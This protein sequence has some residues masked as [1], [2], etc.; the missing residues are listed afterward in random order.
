MIS[1][2]VSPGLDPLVT[3]EMGNGQ[4]NFQPVEVVVDTGFT[5]ELAL[6]AEL[7]QSLGLDY[8]DD[9]RVVLADRV[10][11]WFGAYDGVM[12]WHGEPISVIVLETGGDSLLGMGLLLGSKLTVS[13]RPGGA[14]LIEDE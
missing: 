5:G 7:I 8:I 13:A 6:P 14:V 12:S 9:V 4:G 3:I 2:R 10:E 11:R 1:G